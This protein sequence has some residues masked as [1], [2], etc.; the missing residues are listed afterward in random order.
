MQVPEELAEIENMENV[1]IKLTL[2]A[3]HIGSN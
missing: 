2:S 3:L 1:F